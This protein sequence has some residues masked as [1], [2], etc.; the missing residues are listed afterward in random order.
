MSSVRLEVLWSPVHKDKFIT[1]GTEISLYETSE[2]CGDIRRTDYVDLSETSSARLL[3]TNSSYHYVKAVDIHPMEGSEILLAIGQANGKVS[4]TTFGPSNFDFLG[5]NGMDMVPKHPRQCNVV[6]WCQNDPQLIAAGL[7]RYRSDHCVLVWDIQSR[8]GAAVVAEM[9]LSDMA[10]SLTWLPDHH[11]TLV[12]GMNN[13]LLKMIDLR[14]PSKAAC[15]SQTKAVYGVTAAPYSNFMLASYLESQVSI[16]DIRAFEKPVLTLLQSKPI[17][18]ILWC[19][20]RNNLLGSLQRD[21]KSIYLHYIQ[22]MEELDHSV[23]ERSIRPG[24]SH[25]IT[26]FSWHPL[27][28]NRLLAITLSGLVT[29][30]YVSER[31]TLNWAQSTSIVW[32]H[33]QRTLQSVSCTDSVYEML[34]DI[35]ALM[36]LRATRGYGLQYEMEENGDLVDDE[37]LKLIWRWLGAT[38]RLSDEFNINLPTRHLGIRSVL[39]MDKTTPSSISTK[40]EAVLVPFNGAG[41]NCNAKVY[42]SDVRDKALKLCDWSFIHNLPQLLHAVESLQSQ[43]EV[44]KA[45]A[46]AVFGLQLNTAIKLLSSSTSEHTTISMALSGYSNDNESVWRDACIASRLKLNDPYLRAVF[47]FLTADSDNYN[48]V[49]EEEEMAV[50]D[51]IAFALAYLSDSKLVEYLNKLTD[52]LT[53]DGNLA[54]LILTGMSSSALPLLQQY[55]DSTGDVQSVAIFTMKGFPPSLLES[56]RAQYWISSYRELLDMWRLWDHRAQ[57]DIQHNARTSL[58]PEQQIYVTCSFCMKTLSSNAFSRNK[59]PFPRTKV[60]CCPN[61]RKP[62]PRCSICL[63]NMGTPSQSDASNCNSNNGGMKINTFSSWYTWCQTCRHGGHSK[64][65][66]QWFEDHQEC[67]VT[68]CTCRCLS[69]DATSFTV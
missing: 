26:S 31:I 49:L 67:P 56:N 54:G 24:V 52:Q 8:T 63:I 18:K 58:K 29:D 61:C 23:V 5:I 53:V 11:K 27:D 55:L 60:S 48:S 6:S 64:H 30:T 14:D 34:G 35:S 36:K 21:T 45:V 4:L 1:W 17:T 37:N 22:Q 41:S 16:W 33:G 32:T 15:S 40:S 51:R 43:G 59:G 28:E 19:P 3:A 68:G 2:K 9:G 39:G 46:V 13:K 69:L 10:H 25:Q 12:V 42:R 66:I 38:K 20:T 7:D 44:T 57:F 50:T 62:Q 47:A 65:I